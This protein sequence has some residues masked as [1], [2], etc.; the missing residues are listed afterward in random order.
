MKTFLLL[1]LI[2]AFVLTAFAQNTPNTPPPFM[3]K[4]AFVPKKEGAKPFVG[5]VVQATSA[6]IEYRDPV[7]AEGTTVSNIKDFELIY[8]VEPAEYFAAMDLY[9]AGKYED[10]KAQFK[11]YKDQTK[12]VANLP[13]NYHVLAAFHE[14]ECFRQL[15]DLKS[16]AEALATFPKG[17]LT[18]E[19]QLRQ[20]ELYVLWDAVKSESWERVLVVATEREKQKMPDS[21]LVQVY[22][23]KGLALEK[24]NRPDDALEAYNLAM[25]ADAASS[26]GL[27]AKS[28]IAALGVYHKNPA[29][30]EAITLW[31][32]ED[33]KKGSHGYIKLVEAGALAR[34]YQ[35]YFA[36]IKEIPKEYKKLADYKIKEDPEAL[37]E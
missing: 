9:E 14:L 29:V 28:A 26:E 25:T 15:G 27:V 5:A 1:T 31:G 10:A 34:V 35:A 22:Y 36:H 23:C 17:Q 16:L 32:T 3:I 6:Q 24:L 20:L 12:A 13:G 33:E 2:P 18:R 11:K 30:Q 21:Q 4:A 37:K 8:F 19:F 7:D